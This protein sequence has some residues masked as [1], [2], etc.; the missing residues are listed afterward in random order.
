MEIKNNTIFNITFNFSP[1]KAK[2]SDHNMVDNTKIITN[3]KNY[4]LDK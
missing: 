4:R 1:K 3:K 2:E